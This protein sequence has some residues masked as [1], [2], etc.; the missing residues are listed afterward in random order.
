MKKPKLSDSKFVDFNPYLDIL[1]NTL[2]KCI[3]RENYKAAAIIKKIFNVFDKSSF[4]MEDEYVDELN[5]LAGE[6]SNELSNN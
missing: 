1:E 4:H 3:E 5:K 6:L 2:E